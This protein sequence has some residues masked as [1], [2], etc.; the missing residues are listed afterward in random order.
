MML[1]RLPL[2]MALDADGDG[3]ISTSEM[4][5]A[6]AALKKLDKN[7]DGKLTL[8]ELAPE[9]MRGPFGP[10][11]NFLD[12]EE[13]V[14]RMMMAD[15]NKDGFIDQDEMPERMKA[16]M[17]DR[18]DTDKDGKLSKEELTKMAAQMGPGR[19]GVGPRSDRDGS[20]ES[21]RRR[22]PQSE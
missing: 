11:P 8:D 5:G 9:G 18:G 15:A 6:V 19:G 16:M 2:M 7:S 12:P 3:E 1:A 10:G 13:M 21:G 20:D 4:N 14:N 22:R 17:L